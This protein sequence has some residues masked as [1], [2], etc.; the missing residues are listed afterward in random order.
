MILVGAQIDEGISISAD[1]D[2]SYLPA[3]ARKVRTKCPRPA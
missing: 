3:L 1:K 2:Q